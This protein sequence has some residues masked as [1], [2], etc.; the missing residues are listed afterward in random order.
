MRKCLDVLK[1]INLLVNEVNIINAEAD[2][3]SA[4]NVV[5]KLTECGIVHLTAEVGIIVNGRFLWKTLNN[6]IVV[7]EQANEVA[8]INYVFFSNI[9]W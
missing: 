7:R 6:V 1:N 9:L 5:H 8:D 3:V 4:L 2:D